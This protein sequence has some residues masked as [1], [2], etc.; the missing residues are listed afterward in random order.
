MHSKYNTRWCSASHGGGRV[1]K[2]DSLDLFGCQR[3]SQLHLSERAQALLPQ[4]LHHIAHSAP[5]LHDVLVEPRVAP[6]LNPVLDAPAAKVAVEQHMVARGGALARGAGLRVHG[7]LLD[8]EHARVVQVVRAGVHAPGGGVD[9]AVLDDPRLGRVAQK[10]LDELGQAARLA[11]ELG[12]VELVVLDGLRDGVGRDDVRCV[13]AIKKPEV[14]GG[15]SFCIGG[16]D[17]LGVA[18]KECETHRFKVETAREW[19]AKA[20]SGGGWRQP[21]GLTRIHVNFCRLGPLCKIKASWVEMNGMQKGE[22]ELEQRRQVLG[23]KRCKNDGN[24]S[25][26][27]I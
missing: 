8:L 4:P 11:D 15:S 13:G 19:S 27:V 5:A 20:A 3:R 21:G 18:V 14:S 9:D 26:G 2:S 10:R 24:A 1:A 23:S 7:A 25:G 6:V 17:L 12:C 16:R 22:G